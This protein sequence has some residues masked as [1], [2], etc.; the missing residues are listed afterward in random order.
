MND[1]VNTESATGVFVAV[2]SYMSADGYRDE[3]GYESFDTV[4]A[5]GQWATQNIRESVNVMGSGWNFCADVGWVCHDDFA[6]DRWSLDDDNTVARATW[7]TATGAVVWQ[8]DGP[9]DW[10]E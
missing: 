8:L 7:H 9:F 6:D 1:I 10:T 2:T 5:A 4:G 3:S